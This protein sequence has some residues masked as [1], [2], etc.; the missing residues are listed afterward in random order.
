MVNLKALE[1]AIT[2]VEKI[3]DHE[4]TFKVAD[5]DI[6]LRPLR[7]QEETEIQKY[8]QVAWEGMGEEGDTAKYQEFMDRVRLSTLGF[9]II[10]IGDLDLREVTWLETGEFDEHNNPISV[11]KWTLLL[12][13]GDQR[14]CK[15][16]VIV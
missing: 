3:R 15:L 14:L 11:P 1:A 7:S 12:F 4:F 9:S 10:C 5:Q 6:T 8:A 13:L 16:M 2:Q